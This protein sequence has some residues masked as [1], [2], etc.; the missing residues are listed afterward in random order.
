VSA[1]VC[2]CGRA[3]FSRADG[4]PICSVCLNEPGPGSCKCDPV[5]GSVGDA[6]PVPGPVGEADPVAAV[7]GVGGVR[8]APPETDG[9][10]ADGEL[11]GLARLA[12][13]Y[14]P[15]N[16]AA[17]WK[18]QPPDVD[19]LLEPV[20]EAGTINV[21]FAKPATG[22]SLL[23]LEWSLNLTRQGRTVVYLDDENRVRDLVERLQAFGAEPGELDRLVLYSFAGLPPLDR[24]V[25]GLHLLAVAVTAGAHL[26]VLDT[27]SRMVAGGENDADTFLQL[28]RCSLAP[29]K[30]RGITV[31]R[32]DHPGKD[33]DRGQRGSSAKD[34]DADTIWRL[35]EEK[36]G[37]RYKLHRDKS[38]TS[39]GGDADLTAR[40]RYGPLR[41][42]IT[43][44]DKDREQTAVGQL[45]G[46]LDRLGVPP[47]AGRDRCRTALN[48][49]GIAV[50]NDL[51]AEVVRLRKFGLNRPGQDLSAGDSS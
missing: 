27:T 40:R 13:S 22:K 18:D 30:R 34:G 28:Y 14:A 7:L 51:L 24:P 43:V 44:A 9:G 4:T 48:E 2:T 41:H 21:M 1:G 50:G 3:L 46:Q 16:W 29:L 5:P 45:C 17:A 11:A 38:R 36:D 39:H 23:A 10:E 35:T 8:A 42:E 33:S 12:A 20:L 32:L 15:V 26:V 25:G 31:L 47:S 37:L 6:D 49:A 19:W